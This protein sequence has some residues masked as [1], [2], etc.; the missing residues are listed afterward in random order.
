MQYTVFVRQRPTGLYE[1]IA[2]TIPGSIGKGKTRDEA[3]S[4]LKTVIEDWLVEIEMTTI[5]V[6]VPEAGDRRQLNPWLATAGIFKDDP[7]LEP[8]L[9]EIYAAERSVSQCS[10]GTGR[11]SLNPSL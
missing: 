11:S 4:H 9:A 5:E 10:S 1:A 7:L 3:L 6:D 2:P 8:M